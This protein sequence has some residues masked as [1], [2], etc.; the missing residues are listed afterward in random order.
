M[1]VSQGE[2]PPR[3]SDMGCPDPDSVFIVRGAAGHN[4]TTVE[5]GEHFSSRDAKV[6]DLPHAMRRRAGIDWS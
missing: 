4:H 2:T 3:E 6:G 5:R 1:E